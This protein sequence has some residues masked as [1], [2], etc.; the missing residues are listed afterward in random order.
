MY[1]SL[2]ILIEQIQTLGT[3]VIIPLHST[4]TSLKESTYKNLLIQIKAYDSLSTAL[5]V[6]K[7]ELRAIIEPLLGVERTD[8]FWNFF[9]HDIQENQLARSD[10][11]DYSRNYIVNPFWIALLGT[12]FNIIPPPSDLTQR[13]DLPPMTVGGKRKLACGFMFCLFPTMG[14]PEPIMRFASCITAIRCCFKQTNAQQI[15]LRG[16][17]DI[18]SQQMLGSK[19]INYQLYSFDT[20]SRSALDTLGL[21]VRLKIPGAAESIPQ[22]YADLAID[23]LHN[24]PSSVVKASVLHL[25]EILVLSFPKGINNKIEEIRDATRQ[26]LVDPDPTVV[27]IASRLYVL[28][29]RSASTKQADSFLD[30]L[31]IELDSLVDRNGIKY[32]GDPLIKGLSADQVERELIFKLRSLIIDN[33]LSW[34]AEGNFIIS[35]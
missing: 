7:I 27:N 10:E 24:A 22:E 21:I 31:K 3:G 17:I 25:V 2:R 13:R 4:L 28:L 23:F 8:V 19:Q 35:F 9:L 12:K 29:F 5:A 33:Y 16:F 20:Y 1:Y 34:I 26:L 30:Y 32:A 6:N 18:I 11:Y 15:A 14:M